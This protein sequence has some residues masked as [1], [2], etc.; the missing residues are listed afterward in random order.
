[1]NKDFLKSKATPVIAVILCYILYLSGYFQIIFAV[2]IV[3]LASGIE[4]GKG[5]FKSLGFQR[6]KLKAFDLL[7]VA[8]LVAT[9]MVVLYVHVLVPG[10]TYITGQPMDYSMFQ[11]FEGNIGAIIGLLLFAAVSAGFGEEIFFRGYL[12]RQFTKFFGSS[13]LSIV[14]NILFFGAIFGFIHSYQG[15]SGQIV[16]GILGMITATIFHF[17]KDDLWFAIAFHGFFDLIA[18]GY[19]FYSVSG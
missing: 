13:T 16:T 8:P 1:M 17:R 18:L 12:M 11:Q 5:I 19:Y 15:I 2:P 4:Y 14:L 7:I 6:S 10:V 9:G 3:L